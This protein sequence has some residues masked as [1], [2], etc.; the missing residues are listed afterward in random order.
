MKYPSRLITSLE[1]RREEKERSANTDDNSNR[2]CHFV[3]LRRRLY[4]SKLCGDVGQQCRRV[5][6]GSDA[7]YSGA[8]RCVEGHTLEGVDEHRLALPSGV[9]GFG[10]DI[11]RRSGHDGKE[12]VGGLDRVFARG[13]EAGNRR[14][15]GQLHLDAVSGGVRLELPQEAVFCFR[16]AVAHVDRETH[17]V[18]M[19]MAT[20]CVNRAG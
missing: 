15:A 18:K 16:D 10:L 19:H 7:D 13:R 12:S 4:L 9:L 5:R 6:A 1:Q 8:G 17:G 14:V 3:V 11:W 2:F 20:P